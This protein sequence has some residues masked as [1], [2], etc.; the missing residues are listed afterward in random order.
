MSR[1]S[2][3]GLNCLILGKRSNVLSN[4]YK[5]RFI[6]VTFYVMTLKKII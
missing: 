1:D 4:I 3:T 5:L 2:I 6:A